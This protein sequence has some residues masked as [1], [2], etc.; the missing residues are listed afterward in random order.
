MIQLK[1]N[2]ETVKLGNMRSLKNF[3][4]K[5]KEGN[6]RFL[7]EGKDRKV[8]DLGNRCLKINLMDRSSMGEEGENIREYNRYL[9]TR[10]DEDIKN[11]FR[12][13]YFISGD[14]NYMIC[15]KVMTIEE[16]L[17]EIGIPEIKAYQIYCYNSKYIDN[18]LI[19]NYD[20]DIPKEVIQAL[21][22]LKVDSRKYSTIDELLGVLI[23]KYNFNYS[24]IG[25]IKNW[26]VRKGKDGCY[27]WVATDYEE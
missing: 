11:V 1:K 25:Y 16:Y 17:V 3:S 14:F 5:I 12:D 21:K 27:Y 20:E 8:I 26:G 15:E 19:D 18:I 10:N 23:D 22:D 4:Y 13:I 6:K 9:K 7:G 2:E 24:E